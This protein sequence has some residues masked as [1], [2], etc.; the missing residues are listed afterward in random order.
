VGFFILK[1]YDYWLDLAN[2]GSSVQGLGIVDRVKT[3][4]MC[5]DEDI[6]IPELS[7]Y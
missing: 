3:K 1:I 7:F 6:F 4:L 5:L 2:E